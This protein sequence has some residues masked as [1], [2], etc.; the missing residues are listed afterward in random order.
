MIRP[1]LIG[2]IPHFPVV[3]HTSVKAPVFATWNSLHFP[4]SS[5]VIAGGQYQEGVYSC[6]MDIPK[7]TLLPDKKMY[8][9]HHRIPM[10]PD[11]SR[12]GYPFVVTVDCQYRACI[13]VAKATPQIDFFVGFSHNGGDDDIIRSA[14]YLPCHHHSE[15]SPHNGMTGHGLSTFT[16][17]LPP[18]VE[19]QKGWY[20]CIGFALRAFSGDVH[21]WTTELQFSTSVLYRNRPVFDPSMA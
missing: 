21:L 1:N 19:N 6:S 3:D 13:N 20:A 16:L 15:S 5:E 8:A 7:N 11:D 17:A 10:V 12:P 14:A 9:A 4:F 18:S 2:S